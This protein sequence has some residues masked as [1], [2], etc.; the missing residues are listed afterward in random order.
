MFYAQLA[1]YMAT[2]LDPGIDS[3]APERTTLLDALASHI[4]THQQTHDDATARLI[5]ICTHNSRRSHLSQVWAA[6]GAARFGLDNIETYSG[7]TEATAFN[8][9]AVAALE[10]AGFKISQSLDV[11]G[12]SA[13][14]P[15]Y[16]VAYDTDPDHPALTCFSKCYDDTANPHAGFVAVMTC[17][18]ANEACPRVTGAEARVALMYVDPK[19]GDDTPHEAATYDTRTKQIGIEMMYLMR[20]VKALSKP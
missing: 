10:R 6:V 15:H 17:N 16:R 3:L 14:N 8:P 2:Q 19:E 4:H 1:D 13:T 11:H 5:F 7:G 9:R 20:K 18:H 12:S